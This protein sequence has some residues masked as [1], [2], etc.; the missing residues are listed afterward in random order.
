MKLSGSISAP[1]RKPRAPMKGVVLRPRRPRQPERSGR[2]FSGMGFAAIAIAGIALGVT[3]ALA[4]GRSNA[5]RRMGADTAEAGEPLGRPTPVA[6]RPERFSPPANVI[7]GE[8]A[9]SASST[10]AETEAPRIYVIF[11]DMGL[12][13]AAFDA[14]MT[15]PGPLT[16]SFLPYGRDV[17]QMVNEARDA[18]ASILLHLPMEPTGG[19]DPGP[20]SLAT[21]M[22]EGQ[23]SR[24][25]DANL[26][27]FTGYVGVNNHMGSR[28][29]RNDRAMRSVLGVLKA[30]GLFFLDSRTTGRSVA[31]SAGRATGATVLRRDVFLDADAD[32][33][34]ILRQLRRVEEIA[35][36]EGSVIAI[37]HPRKATLEA[38]GPWLTSAPARG[39]KLATARD[40]LTSE[41]TESPPPL[42]SGW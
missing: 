12:D 41:Q 31:E 19:A 16:L 26:N 34:S 29:T 10:E 28:F 32:R 22:S 23:L 36:R 38:L 9:A 5:L 20:N 2:W 1:R 11:D 35:R 8:K 30:N 24:T 14:V 3:S 27:A 39:F 4:D 6:F 15:L 21:S 42:R 13:R 37:A 40:L 7:S 18:G 33:D 17:Q 25:L